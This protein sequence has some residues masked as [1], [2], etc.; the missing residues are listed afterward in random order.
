[1]ALDAIC[2][3]PIALAA[4]TLEV[5]AP[6]ANLADVIPPSLTSTNLEQ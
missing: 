2:E 4:K 5:M 3:A 1:M 6:L